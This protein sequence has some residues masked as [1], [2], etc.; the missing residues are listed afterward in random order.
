[1]GIAA[2]R[3]VRIAHRMEG[4]IGLAIAYA[5]GLLTRCLMGWRGEFGGDALWAEPKV[6]RE[7]TCPKQ[8]VDRPCITC[9]YSPQVNKEEEGRRPARAPSFASPHV[10]VLGSRSCHG[11]QSEAIRSGLRRQF[12]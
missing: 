11:E 2:D 8:G 4:A 10:S 3:A 6:D 9:W 7:N 12:M 1:M 5:L